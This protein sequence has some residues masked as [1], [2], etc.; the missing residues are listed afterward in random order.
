M[1]SQKG[2]SFFNLHLEKIKKSLVLEKAS[3]CACFLLFCD[4]LTRHP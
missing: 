2:G 1:V 3:F 4:L